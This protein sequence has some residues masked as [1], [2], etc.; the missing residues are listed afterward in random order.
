MNPLHQVPPRVRAWVYGVYA[1]LSLA[2][3]SAQV[4]Y[5]AVPADSPTWLRVALVVLPFVGLGIGATAATHVPAAPD[6]VGRP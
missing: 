4:G 1:V 2:L 6:V 3:G 5:A